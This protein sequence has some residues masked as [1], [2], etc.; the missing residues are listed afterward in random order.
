MKLTVGAKYIYY[1][2]KDDWVRWVPIKY[3]ATVLAEYPTY[4]LLSLKA[5]SSTVPGAL[6]DSI[7]YR[8]C[9]D[10]RD[11]GVMDKFKSYKK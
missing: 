11:V 10:K 8:C 5:I 9:V 7:P 4:Y 1:H 6:S 2:G 3:V